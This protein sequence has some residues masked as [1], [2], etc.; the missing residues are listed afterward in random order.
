MTL[1][2][3]KPQQMAGKQLPS[4]SEDGMLRHVF[5]YEDSAGFSIY[6]SRGYISQGLKGESYVFFSHSLT[7]LL[8]VNVVPQSPVK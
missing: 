8:P 3:E 4:A 1:E 6:F 7:S 2:H 5:Y